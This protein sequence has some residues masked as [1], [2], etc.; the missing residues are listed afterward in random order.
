M[1]A[2]RSFFRLGQFGAA[3]AE[4]AQGVLDDLFARRRQGG[5]G[6]AGADRL[7]FGEQRFVLG[8]RGP[9]FG[10][11]GL[12][13]VVGGA[14]FGRV[15]HVVEVADHAPGAAQL[16][17]RFFER[18]DEIVPGDARRTGASSS[19]LTTALGVRRSAG[20]WPA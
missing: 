9:E 12:V 17:G 18:D 11:L 6:G 3:Q 19:L 7:V 2:K 4:V 13:V 15:H 5:V 8:Q 10:H 20:R 16:F 1:S 14:Q